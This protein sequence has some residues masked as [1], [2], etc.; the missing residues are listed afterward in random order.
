MATPK[1][2]PSRVNTTYCTNRL[3]VDYPHV[4]L[5]DVED[6]SVWIARKRF[7]KNP[8]N[9]SHARL[10][11]GGS[12]S[13]STADKD[14]YVCFWY[15]TP[16]SGEGMVHG[17]PIE[18]DE[19]HLLIRLDPNW[20]YATQAYIPNTAARRIEK[21]IDQQYAWGRHLFETYASKH[22]GFPLSWHM[23]GPRAKD[24]MFY[25]ERIENP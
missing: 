22:P 2:K 23:I 3:R 19:G 12:N 10:L 1:P 7:G 8:S 15:H 25:I 24:S 21:N 13:S 11:K 9:I 5:F 16:A 20:S 14:R 4:G 17:Y 18:W 6:R